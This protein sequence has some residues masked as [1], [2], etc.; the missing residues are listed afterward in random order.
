MQFAAIL[1]LKFSVVTGLYAVIPMLWNNAKICGVAEKL[2]S[3]RSV[4]MPVLERDQ[5]PSRNPA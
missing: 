4:D 5:S 1:G 2:A 3:V